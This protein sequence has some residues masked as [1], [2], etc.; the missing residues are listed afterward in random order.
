[1]ELFHQL[2]DLGSKNYFYKNFLI[3]TKEFQIDF[4]NRKRNYLNRKWNYLS[5]FHLALLS[6]TSLNKMLSI[7][8]IL[9]I[10]SFLNLFSSQPMEVLPCI[11]Y[12]TSGP[13]IKKLLIQD[14]ATLGSILDSQPSW[15]SGKFQLARWSHEVVIFPE[16]TT[17][18]PTDHMDF[19]VWLS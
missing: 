12:A 6:K 14:V 11:I 16:R 15:E 9:P 13:L 2:P 7:L 10:L 19:L 1:M 8:S 4:P 5:H 17:Y 18:P 3:S